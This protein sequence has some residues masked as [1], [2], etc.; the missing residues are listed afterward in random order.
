MN[1]VVI[2]AP[3]DDEEFTTLTRT[4]VNSFLDASNYRFVVSRV[5]MAPHTTMFTVGPLFPVAHYRFPSR[6]IY[7]QWV[8]AV[9]R[10]RNHMSE[11]AGGG[12]SHEIQMS[13]TSD[14]QM[15]AHM[16]EFF[17]LLEQIV[18]DFGIQMMP[19]DIYCAA[20][21]SN[22]MLEDLGRPRMD[23]FDAIS[24]PPRHAGCEL[25]GIYD[26]NEFGRGKMVPFE[27][28]S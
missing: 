28:V 14:E 7:R 26:S 15:V 19:P 8:C 5:I 9:D 2:L 6:E 22:R 21:T 24:E 10:A 1:H 27:P 11:G 18:R 3:N 16:A 4:N 25:L 17:R 12:A 20:Q 13:W 23:A